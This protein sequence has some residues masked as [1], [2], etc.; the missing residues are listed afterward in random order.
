MGSPTATVPD[1]ESMPLCGKRVMLDET[2]DMRAN[3]CM[4]A[5][6]SPQ[7]ENGHSRSFCVL[8]GRDAPESAGIWDTLSGLRIPGEE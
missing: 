6:L 2:R 3:C 1:R 8:G 4:L 5:V 7:G